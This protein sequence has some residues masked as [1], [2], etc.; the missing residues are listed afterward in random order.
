MKAGIINKRPL[1]VETMFGN[2]LR[3]AAAAGAD[4]PLIGMLYRQLK[5]LDAKNR[6][7]IL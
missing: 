2:P 6:R 7:K 1:E 5:F 4:L 3:T